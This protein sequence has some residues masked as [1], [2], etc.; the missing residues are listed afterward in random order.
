MPWIVSPS[1]A[2]RDT[3]VSRCSGR[4]ASTPSD[5]MENPCGKSAVSKIDS[6]WG[7]FSQTTTVEGMK[8]FLPPT[9]VETIYT[10]GASPS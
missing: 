8:T 5:G 7:R 10:T 9:G 2:G 3:S 6:V 4:T 1:S